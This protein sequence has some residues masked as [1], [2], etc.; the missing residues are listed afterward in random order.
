[1]QI[2]SIFEYTNGRPVFGVVGTDSPLYVPL[3]GFFA[4]TGIPTSVRTPV[5]TCS[6]CLRCRIFSF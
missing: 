5:L 1:L 2:G 4:V 3:L 6:T